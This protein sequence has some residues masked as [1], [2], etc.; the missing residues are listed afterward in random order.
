MSAFQWHFLNCLFNRSDHTY[1]TI[2]QHGFNVYSIFVYVCVSVYVCLYT[3]N[4]EINQYKANN[5]I[6]YKIYVW[7]VTFEQ[8]HMCALRIF[9]AITNYGYRY[10]IFEKISLYKWIKK[11][12]H[13]YFQTFVY[14]VL[15]FHRRFFFN[16]LF[17]IWS[18]KN[19]KNSCSVKKIM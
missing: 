3:S 10:Y 18:M 7:C 12:T 15:F 17:Q 4:R 6:V 14:V 1:V 9:H 5:R 11:N 16:F 19:R 13:F 2:M 8:V